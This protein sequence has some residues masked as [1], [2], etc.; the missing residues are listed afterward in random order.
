MK[1]THRDIVLSYS[2]IYPLHFSQ[3]FHFKGHV[4]LYLWLNV[5]IFVVAGKPISKFRISVII[6]SQ[7]VIE[8]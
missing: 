2:L 3:P 4:H 6:D 1:Y 8:L 5:Y 7:G